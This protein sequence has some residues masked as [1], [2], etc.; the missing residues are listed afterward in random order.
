MEN[1][2]NELWAK[3]ID[4]EEGKEMRMKYIKRIT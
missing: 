1:S 3:S 2:T 4:G